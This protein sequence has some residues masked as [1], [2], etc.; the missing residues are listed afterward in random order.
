[1]K[2]EAGSLVLP[3]FFA[4]F[5]LRNKLKQQDN[6]REQQPT[7]FADRTVDGRGAG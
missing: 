5:A 1:M 4:T 3:A 2:K 7:E 6:G